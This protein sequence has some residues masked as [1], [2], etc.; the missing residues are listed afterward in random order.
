[1]KNVKSEKFNNPLIT[2]E[3]L[4]QPRIL[5]AYHGR[6]LCIGNRIIDPSDRLRRDH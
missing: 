1:M 5:A 6:L 4:K 3:Y 2:A